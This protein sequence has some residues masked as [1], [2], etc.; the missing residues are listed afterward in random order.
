MRYYSIFTRKAAIKV[1]VTSIG[2]DVWKLE[3][4]YIVGGNVKWH[5]CFA[6]LICSSS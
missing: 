3:H 6:K 4:L 5:S 2:E 1:I